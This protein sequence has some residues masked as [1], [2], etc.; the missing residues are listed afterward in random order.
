MNIQS[1]QLVKPSY[2]LT[3]GRAAA[4]AESTTFSLGEDLKDA[5][6]L[7]GSSALPVVGAALNYVAGIGAGFNHDDLAVNACLAGAGAN[8]LGT[9]TLAGGLITGNHTASY[10]GLALLGV[11]GLTVANAVMRRSQV[12]P[13]G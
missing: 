13:K 8:L 4:P 2:T 12:F 10:A 3:S 6:M 9:A 5:V 11:S 7:G 1:T